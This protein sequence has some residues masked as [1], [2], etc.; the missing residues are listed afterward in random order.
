MSRQAFQERQEIK[1]KQENRNK[2]I[3]AALMALTMTAAMMTSCGNKKQDDESNTSDA[4]PTDA[5]TFEIVPTDADTT[6]DETDAV[7]TDD[8]L[9]DA[10]DDADINVL[11]EGKNEIVQKVEGYNGKA[12]RSVFRLEDQTADA[13][14]SCFTDD[15]YIDARSFARDQDLHITVTFEYIDFFKQQLE[16][17]AT[18]LNKTAIMITPCHAN[19]RAKFANVKGAMITE[20]PNAADFPAAGSWGSENSEWV[21]VNGED[22]AT[23]ASVKSAESIEDKKAKKTAL[24]MPE[25]FVRSDGFIRVTDKEVRKIEFTIPAEEVNKMLDGIYGA[26]EISDDGEYNDYNDYDNG[27]TDYN[28]GYT[29]YNNGYTDYNNGY[30]D[31]NNG[32]N[33]YG[34]NGYGMGGAD[35]YLVDGTWDYTDSAADTTGYYTT[36]SVTD[37]DA[38]SSS[39][40]DTAAPAPADWDGIFLQLGGNIYITKISIDQGNVFL[41]STMNKS[42]S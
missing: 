37:S 34:Y 35:D 15:D 14:G 23:P 8:E 28:N 7:S 13:W 42:L 1:M 20:Y 27:Y 29:D 16:S 17:G 12:R 33:D 2:K 21:Q 9:S 38:D 26:P 18:D 25:I 40:A 39:E 30:T 5:Q 4:L 3:L 24:D 6:A 22:L 11:Q 19:G 36:D 41:N 10:E 32:Y 31:Y